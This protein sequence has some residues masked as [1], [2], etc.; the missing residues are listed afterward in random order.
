M[1]SEVFLPE[2]WDPS[3][4]YLELTVYVT[5]EILMHFSGRYQ[6]S[7]I[8]FKPKQPFSHPN[9]R[10]FNFSSSLRVVTPAPVDTGVA[11][12]VSSLG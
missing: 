1:V 5:C 4:T 12:P 7:N 2:I 6:K 8:S 9:R 11:R 10:L 3:F